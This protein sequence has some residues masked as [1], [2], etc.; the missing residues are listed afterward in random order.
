VDFDAASTVRVSL[1]MDGTATGLDNTYEGMK[2]LDISPDGKLVIACGVGYGGN[3]VRVMLANIEGCSQTNGVGCGVMEWALYDADSQSCKFDPSGTYVLIGFGNGKVMYVPVQQPGTGAGRILAS[4]AS[5]GRIQYSSDTRYVW[6]G[7][8]KS[9]LALAFHPTEPY[10]LAACYGGTIYKLDLSALPSGAVTA[11]KVLGTGGNSVDNTNVTECGASYNIGES[12]YGS[13]MEFVKDDSTDT[14]H[15]ILM[16]MYGRLLRKIDL[17][18]WCVTVL[19]TLA[20]EGRTTTLHPSQEYLLAV[21]SLQVKKQSLRFPYE[22]TDLAGLGSKSKEVGTEPYIL[23]SEVDLKKAPGQSQ[24]RG[25]AAMGV[26]F[27]P[28]ADYA[29]FGATGKEIYMISAVPPPQGYASLG[30]GG[31][32]TASDQ[33]DPALQFQSGATSAQCAEKCTEAS[34]CDAYVLRASDG[35]CYTYS[36]GPY[37]KADPVGNDGY[38]CFVKQA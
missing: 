19:S 3:R 33:Y 37:T 25:K 20:A 14:Y 30:Q 16:G 32:R 1:A 17:A 24:T 4:S 9:I 12:Y 36:N 29:L 2:G 35:V 8:S 22:V 6:N 10:A 38:E 34:S 18:T 28:N 21:D 5:G 11:E 15:L 26:D 13:A 7:I 27:S 23:G 31:C